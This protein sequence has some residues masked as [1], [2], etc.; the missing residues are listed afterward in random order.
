LETIRSRCIRLPIYSSEE[1]PQGEYEKKATAW[2]NSFFG[3]GAIYDVAAAFQ[4]ARH[5]Q[6]LL[7]A[8][9]EEASESA[10]EEFHLEKQHFGKTTEGNWEGAREQYFKATAEASVLSHRS[11]LIDVVAA[12]FGKQL[13]EASQISSQKEIVRLLRALEVVEKLR[14]SLEGGVQEALALEAGFLELVNTASKE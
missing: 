9:R 6:G 11:L 4:L 3:E 7:A 1:P 8:I 2:M 12:H 13:K 14:G 5:F 10:E